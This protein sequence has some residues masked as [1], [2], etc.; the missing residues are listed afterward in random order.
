MQFLETLCIINGIPRHLEWHQRRLEAT[1]NFYYPGLIHEQPLEIK[2]I[3]ASIDLPLDG[4]WRCR[5][6]Y[7][8]N[9]VSV[10][11]IPD[12]MTDYSTLTMI[13]VSK[14][15]D[16]RYKYADRKFL[17]DLYEKRGEA[18][19]IL[20]LRDGWIGDTTK[21]NIAF[22]AGERWY[23]PSLT[24]LAGTTW[25][26]LVSEGVLIPKPIHRD[27]LHRYEA[28]KIINALNGW[29]GKEFPVTGILG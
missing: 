11:M 10:E 16:Y 8:L 2:Q 13:E 12:G 25:K 15:F 5:I 4:I 26:R 24:F 21:A 29:D 28:F 18:A 3:L 23:T 14:D 1:L 7:D 22:R 20:M 27:H 6:I 9:A 19:D 17:S